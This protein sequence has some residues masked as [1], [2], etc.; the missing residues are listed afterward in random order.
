MDRSW[1]SRS[2]TTPTS[3]YRPKL[4]RTVYTVR[5]LPISERASRN[6]R[7]AGWYTKVWPTITVL[8]S[9]SDSNLTR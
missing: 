9:R 5:S 6:R 2:G 1:G 8:S 7:T 4:A 3:W